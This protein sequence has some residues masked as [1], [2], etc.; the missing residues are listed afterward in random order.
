MLIKLQDILW[1]TKSNTLKMYAIYLLPELVH[2]IS[3]D[4]FRTIYESSPE[5]IFTTCRRNPFID[6][7]WN[8]FVDATK[9]SRTK[10]SIKDIGSGKEFY[11][12]FPVRPILD[13]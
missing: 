9:K 7:Q 11:F 13:F 6:L 4:F 3:Q 12:F 5:N 10:I 8:L 2:S 1:A